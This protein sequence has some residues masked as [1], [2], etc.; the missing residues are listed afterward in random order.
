MKNIHCFAGTR[1]RWML[2]R[3]DIVVTYV[4][5]PGGAAKFKALAE[6]KGKHVIE[7]AGITACSR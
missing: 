2:E 3:S 5:S 4:R 1:N 6:R 7:V